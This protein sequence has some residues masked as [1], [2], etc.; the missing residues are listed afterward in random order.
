[1]FFLVPFSRTG[2][3]GKKLVFVHACYL[4]KKVKE[5]GI[6][7]HLPVTPIAG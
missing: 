2:Q 7:I 3:H 5:K 6:L 4:P 1:M